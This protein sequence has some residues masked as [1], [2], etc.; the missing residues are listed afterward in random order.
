MSS[1]FFGS[2]ISGLDLDAMLRKLEDYAAGLMDKH[3]NSPVTCGG[4]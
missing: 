4:Y 1:Q 2:S 3:P